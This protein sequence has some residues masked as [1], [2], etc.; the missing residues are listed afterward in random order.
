[1]QKLNCV[2][3]EKLILIDSTELVDVND[4]KV[5]VIAGE[6][7]EVVGI[8]EFGIDLELIENRNVKVRVLNSQLLE[9]FQ[10]PKLT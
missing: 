10:K 4:S 7:F 9:Y 3:N 2:I 6:L 5:S 8:V 1:M